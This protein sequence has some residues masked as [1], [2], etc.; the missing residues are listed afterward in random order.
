MLYNASL[1]N[2]EHEFLCYKVL[3]LSLTVIKSIQT[4]IHTLQIDI[5]KTLRGLYSKELHREIELK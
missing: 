3:R 4:N 2:S 1:Y 5:Y